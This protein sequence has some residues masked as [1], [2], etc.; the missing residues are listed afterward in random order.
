VQTPVGNNDWYMFTGIFLTYKI[1]NVINECPAYE[2]RVYRLNSQSKVGK[3]ERWFIKP[4][5]T[6]ESILEKIGAVK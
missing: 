3:S 6:R 1:F 2:V 5:E 4:H